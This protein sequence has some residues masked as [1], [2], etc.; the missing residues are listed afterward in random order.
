GQIG[1]HG[2]LHGGAV[3]LIRGADVVVQGHEGKLRLLGIVPGRI[4][5]GVGFCIPPPC[6]SGEVAGVSWA[7]PARAGSASRSTSAKASHF[8]IFSFLLC[9]GLHIHTLFL[10]PS[11]RRP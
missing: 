11:P 4:R 8:F 9:L 2:R 6:A 3:V 7:Q 5:R 1:V 10:S